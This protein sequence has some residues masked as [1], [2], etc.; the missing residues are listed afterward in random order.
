MLAGIALLAFIA[1]DDRVLLL[2]RLSATGSRSSAST[3]VATVAPAA[4]VAHNPKSVQQDG[5][6]EQPNVATLRSGTSVHRHEHKRSH[7]RSATSTKA[8]LVRDPVPNKL[9]EQHYARATHILRTLGKLPTVVDS[10]RLIWTLALSLAALQETG[11]FVETGVY[12]GGTSIAMMRALDLERD[13]RKH[14]A[15]DSFRG[16][17]AKAEQDKV[18]T[19]EPKACST[20]SNSTRRSSPP[21]TAAICS[22][23]QRG[24][25]TGKWAS[26]RAEFEENVRKFNASVARLRVVEGWFSD[27][28]PPPGLGRIAFLRLDGDLY[29][30]TRDALERLEP[31]VSH[32]G[33]IYVDDYGSFRGC[34][35]AVDEYLAA[36][37]DP[38]KLQ[39]ITVGRL[40]K[41]Q[42]LWWRKR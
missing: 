19:Y 42:A 32:G 15:C 28:L 13:S 6:D 17:P 7:H 14:W 18:T 5:R 24:F 37:G 22:R 41:F 36:R 21:S 3:S 23:P 4:E 26:S 33:Y 29:N 9:L 34:A 35:A 20:A 1:F 40:G 10:A 12:R 39:P 2:I 11:D 16:V 25:S 30:S 38:P 31:L 8:R 27:T